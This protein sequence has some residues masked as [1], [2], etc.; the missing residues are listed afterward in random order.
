ME[1]R[2]PQANDLHAEMFLQGVRFL[3]E[4]GYEVYEL[5]NAAQPGHVCRHNLLYW[6]GGEWIGMGLSASS[7]FI[8]EDSICERDSGS[9]GDRS[10]QGEYFSN[11]GT[12]DAYMRCWQT[13]PDS[14]PVG[15]IETTLESRMLD[16]IMLHLRTSQGLL[17]DELTR[18]GRKPHSIPQTFLQELV[19]HGYIAELPGRIVLTPRGWLLHS[20]ITTRLMAWL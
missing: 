15:V 8:L 3:N 6:T 2:S 19:R 14:L 5:S 11:P 20:E 13:V 12:W 4:H 18:F 17:L 7:Y 10:P 16:W 9:K 1:V